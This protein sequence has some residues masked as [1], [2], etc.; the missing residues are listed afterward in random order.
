MADIVASLAAVLRTAGYRTGNANPGGVIPEIKEPVLAVN[1]ERANMEE[2]TLVVR[3]TV[4]VPLSM[5]AKA[6]ESHALNVCRL[7]SGIGY[8]CEMQPSKFDSKTEIFS[9]AVLVH[10]CGNITDQ[11]WNADDTL[12]VRLGSG[13]YLNK[14]LSFTAWQEPEEGQALGESDWQIQVE[15]K[16]DGIQQE[17]V[18]SGITTITVYF[19]AGQ[20]VYS[21]CTLSGRKRTI[22]DG[23]LVQIWEAVAKSR[24]IHI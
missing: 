18:P 14:V 19:E 9:S 13:F 22:R 7:L 8:S 23:K 4:V 16:L 10:F 12:Q 20:E 6:C 21:E 5:G 17:N 15:E 24:T 1:L 11:N 3:I 2:K